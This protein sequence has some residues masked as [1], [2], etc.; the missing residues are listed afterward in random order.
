MRLVLQA[1][2][3]T[4]FS[5]MSVN[6][7]LQD[8]NDNRPRFQLQNY[9]AYLWEAQGYD[10]PVIQVSIRREGR[11]AWSAHCGLGVLAIS[12]HQVEMSWGHCEGEMVCAACYLAGTQRWLWSPTK[13]PKEIGEPGWGQL[14]ICRTFRV[15]RMAGCG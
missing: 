15:L 2:S 4:S 11:K 10:S 9:V 13:G 6:I 1:E 14:S 8:V 12:L 3:A 5:F 7:H